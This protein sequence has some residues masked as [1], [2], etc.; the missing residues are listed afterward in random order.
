M[1]HLEALACLAALFILLA[2]FFQAS[3]SL[4]SSSQES[5][6]FFEARLLAE[7]HAFYVDGVYNNTASQSLDRQMPCQKDKGKIVCRV[8]LKEASA[9]LENKPGILTQDS[10]VRGNGHYQ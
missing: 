9:S 7:S 8:N 2:F 5:L 4:Y 3:Q 6:D 10:R 1:L